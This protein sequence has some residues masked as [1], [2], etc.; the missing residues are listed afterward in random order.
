MKNVLKILL[1][2]I[3][4]FA[5]ISC[6][7]IELTEP[8]NL[9]PLT[10]DQDP[11]LPS[12]IVNGAKLHSE[13][14]GHPDS[15]IIV[16]I[17]GGPG[18][19]YR[20]MLNCKDFAN[21]GYRVVF[22][23]QRGS[24]LS[25]RFSKES[26]TSLGKGALDLIYDELSG[27]IAHYRTH[28]GQKVF[29]LGH[30]WGAMLATAYAGK[31]PDTIQGLSIQEPGGLKWDDIMTFISNSQSFSLFGELSSDATYQDQFMT[32]KANQHEIVDYKFAMLASKNDITGDDD[33]EAGS[34]WR[35]GYIMRSGLLEIGTK[36]Q[37]DFSEGIDNFNIPILFFYSE[38]DK[39]Y[40]EN[41]AIKITSVF[42]QVEAHKVPGVGH[43][44]IIS[45]QKAWRETTLPKMVSYFNSL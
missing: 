13:A 5:I 37:P 20:Y 18:G 45:D 44:G 28:Q 6:E 19:D 35:L 14:F 26:Y 27:V 15:T 43:K 42:N 38:L 8:G 17:H 32:G 21:Y 23:D 33:T 29:L 3:M 31:Y 40:P 12:I 22:Y 36:Y 2:T 11:N 16:A 7:E 41:W 30:S 34:F 24:G 4:S 9:V 25:Q 39:A 1:G 10:V